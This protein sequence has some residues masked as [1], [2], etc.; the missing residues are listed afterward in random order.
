L[1]AT[2]VSVNTTLFENKRSIPK[3]RIETLSDLIFGLALS[4]GALSLLGNPPRTNAEITS[5][6]ASYGFSFLILVTVW[7]RYTIIMSAL[8]IETRSTIFLNIAMLFLVSIEPYLFYLVS[9][10]D[11]SQ[12][13]ALLEYA[14]VLYSIDMGALM[15]ILAVFSHELTIEEKKLVS[16]EFLGRWKRIRNYLFIVAALFLLSAMP[17]FWSWKLD[18]TPLRFYFWYV[19]LVVA[20]IRGA[21]PKDR[22]RRQQ[23]ETSADAKD[24]PVVS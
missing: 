20:W 24:S 3:P 11:H 23:K 8:P 16:L 14:S 17:Q 13:S 1:R 6:I 7:L 9:L 18:S 5:D 22:V 12:Q 10:F 15:I 19:P 4:I 2:A 21:L